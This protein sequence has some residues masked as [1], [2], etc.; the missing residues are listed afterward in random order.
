[1]ANIT[2]PSNITERGLLQPSD[3]LNLYDFINT[4]TWNTL[5]IPNATASNNPVAL[6]QFSTSQ[7]GNG[8]FN[9]PNPADPGN[10]TII[11]WGSA[12]VTGGTQLIVTLP[13]T[14]PNNMLQVYASPEVNSSTASVFSN[15]ISL[16]LS[17]IGLS[18]NGTSTVGVSWMAIGN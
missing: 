4:G 9:I 14:F 3:L 8:Y 16:S 5:T 12:F 17:T 15:A 2:I 11:Q 7:G 1:M 6:G 18:I 10:P 13:L